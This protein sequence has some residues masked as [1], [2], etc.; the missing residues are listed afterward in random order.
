MHIAIA[1]EL[2]PYKYV[3]III[4]TI[5]IAIVIIIIIIITIIIII[6]IIILMSAFFHVSCRQ[7]WKYTSLVSLWSPLF[8]SR[9]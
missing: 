1:M 7:K 3:N 8:S 4:I 2:A 9:S 6:I 5:I